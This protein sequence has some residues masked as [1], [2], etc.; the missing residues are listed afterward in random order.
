MKILLDTVVFL[1]IISGSS[2]LSKKSLALFSDSHNDIYMSVISIWE[3]ILKYKLGKLPLPESPDVMIPAQASRHDIIIL[4]LDEQSVYS[5]LKIPRYH[6]DPFDRMLVC[7]A[8]NYHMTILTP[9]KYIRKYKV[10]VIW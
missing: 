8:V 7:Q 3:I 6:N 9:D 1:Q 5:L 2:S 4:P 10:N